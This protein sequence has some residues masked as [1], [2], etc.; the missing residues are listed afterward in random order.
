MYLPEIFRVR[1]RGPVA[2]AAGDD[3]LFSRCTLGFGV[4]ADQASF[5]VT[6]RPEFMLKFEILGV[7]N[8]PLGVA[9]YAERVAAYPLHQG[10]LFPGPCN[11]E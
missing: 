9:L 3:S 7:G 8:R 2:L 11:V 4:V 5:E 6:L 10:N 1:D